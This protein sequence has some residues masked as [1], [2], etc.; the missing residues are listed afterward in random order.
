MTPRDAF[1]RACRLDVQVRKPG[2]V[3]LAS[4]GHGMDAAMFLASAQAAS[5]P[6]FESALGV[7]ERID[8]AVEAT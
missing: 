5:G 1:L 4:P 6:L 7:G 2:N 3:S 8:K